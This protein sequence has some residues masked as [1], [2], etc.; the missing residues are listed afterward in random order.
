MSGR[1]PLESILRVQPTS[2]L[3]SDDI[4]ALV[5]S[6]RDVAGA[7]QAADPAQKAEVHAELG[8]SVTYHTNRRFLVEARPRVVDVGVGGGT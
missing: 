2:Q 6:L 3:T 8:I 4:K 7:L 5:T 1:V